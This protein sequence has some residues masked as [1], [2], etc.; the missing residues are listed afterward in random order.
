MYYTFD[1]CM[2]VAHID[3]T[4]SQHQSSNRITENYRILK[5]MEKSS[6]IAKLDEALVKSK[7][8]LI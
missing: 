2:D 4:M 8:Y 1:D 7:E 6:V 3:F 5:T